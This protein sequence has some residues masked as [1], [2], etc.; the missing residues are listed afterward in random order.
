MVSAPL[1]A[2]VGDFDVAYSSNG[3]S[4]GV[5]VLLAG[6]PVI[7]WLDDQDLNLSDLRGWPDVRFVGESTDL[8]DALRAVADGGVGSS[9]STEFFTLDAEL[10]RWRRLLEADCHR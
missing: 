4:A 7:V 5:D 2:L 6:L 3:T 10:P 9:A 8:V 1:S